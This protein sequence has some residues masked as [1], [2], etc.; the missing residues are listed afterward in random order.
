MT[1]LKI[2]SLLL[3]IVNTVTV[4]AAVLLQFLEKTH[5][6]AMHIHSMQ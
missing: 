4:T 3:A 1:I 6:V 2:T 5:P